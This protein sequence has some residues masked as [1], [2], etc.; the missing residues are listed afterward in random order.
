MV[1]M[2]R[3]LRPECRRKVWLTTVAAGLLLAGCTAGPAEM[4]PDTAALEDAQL[5][6][7]QQA[8]S[9]YNYADAV[10]IYQGLHAAK[11]DDAQLTLSLAR[12]LRFAGQP[13]NAI[14][15][16]SQLVGKQGRTVP[17]LTELGKAYLAAD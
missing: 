11:P 13:Q 3:P 1:G 6:A 7:A 4:K 12:N 9:T 17:L 5:K 8:E 10:N 14:S 2:T 16:I 15:I